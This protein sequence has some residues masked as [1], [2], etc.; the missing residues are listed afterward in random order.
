MTYLK[1]RR[2]WARPLTF[3]WRCQ[4]KNITEQI[5]MGAT[6]LDIRVRYDKK[7]G[8][9][10]LCHGIVHLGDKCYTML[11]GLLRELPEM[12]MRVVLERGDSIDEE[13]FVGLSQ[14]IRQRFP[15]VTL[16]GIKAGWETIYCNKEIENIVADLFYKP[17][18]SAKGLWSNLWYA[19]THLS[20]IVSYSKKIPYSELKEYNNII[21][22][23]DRI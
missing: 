15:N 21:Y 13:R 22:L 7:H 20:T 4:T 5:A 11:P 17:S 23:V 3:L 8:G 10:R 1:P 9:W 2:W 14:V 19:L 16:F 18:D 6:Y 12:S